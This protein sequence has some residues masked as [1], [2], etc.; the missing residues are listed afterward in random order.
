MEIFPKFF[1]EYEFS[2]KKKIFVCH[3]S[4]RAQ[5][6]PPSW[7]RDHY[8]TAKPARPMW[9]TGS[10]NLSPIDASGN[11]IRFTEVQVLNLPNLIKVLLHLGKTPVEEI[12]GT[13]GAVHYGNVHVCIEPA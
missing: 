3:Y 2:D 6:M 10:L 7:V 1:T 13:P 12:T 11:V 9:E 8:A 5:I 4:K